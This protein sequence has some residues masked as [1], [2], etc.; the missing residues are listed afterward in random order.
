MKPFDPFVLIT[1]F[2]AQAEAWLQL[3]Q[4]DKAIQSMKTLRTK[5]PDKDEPSSARLLACKHY[6]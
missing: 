4:P 1:T 6:S 2:N 5:L 3:K